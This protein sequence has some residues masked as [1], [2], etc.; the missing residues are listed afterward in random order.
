MIVPLLAGCGTPAPGSDLPTAKTH[1]EEAKAWAKEWRADAQLIGIF[2]LELSRPAQN[3]SNEI[4]DL[5]PEYYRDMWSHADPVVGDGRAPVWAYT[6][7]SGND[8]SW[9]TYAQNG[10]SRQG[11]LAPVWGPL[12]KLIPAVTP[13]STD[14]D[15][16]LR[17]VHGA[18]DFRARVGDGD[19]S[20]VE[21]ALCNSN[22]TMV[23]RMDVSPRGA[24]FNL[25]VDANS[26]LLL[27]GDWPCLTLPDI[28][29]DSG[30]T[31]GILPLP[32]QDAV[33]SF[34]LNRTHSEMP[35][36]LNA[37]TSGG[38]VKMTMTVTRPD[39]QSSQTGLSL[40]APSTP[41]QSLS[42]QDVVKPVLAGP[43]KATIH[44]DAGINAAYTLSWC[45]DRDEPS[46]PACSP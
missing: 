2:G 6:F 44:L 1:L 38:P 12:L 28:L 36:L 19:A 35:I 3:V 21:E 16:A 14:S 42:T 24:P 45:P 40:L 41:G 10:T 39:G 43:Y 29:H 33:I 9:V 34:T 20:Q 25:V 15:E 23:W 22:G 30:S 8:G 31:S 26:G 32:G 4:P 5:F 7:L 37:T 13:W 18:A 17:V 46:N 27:T 11:S